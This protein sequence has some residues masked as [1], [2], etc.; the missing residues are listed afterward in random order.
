MKKKLFGLL[1]ACF[2][3]VSAHASD[4]GVGLNLGLSTKSGFSTGFIGA[5]GIIGLP[6]KLAVAPSFNYW[7]PNTQD[8][9]KLKCLDANIDLHFNLLD[10]GLLKVYPLVGLNYMR[11]DLEN[12][13]WG[14]SVDGGESN[15]VG[16]NLGAGAQIRFLP[17][18]GASLEAKGLLIDGFT[19]FIPSATLYFLF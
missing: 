12:T 7:F 16:A 2:V 1:A 15:K 13:V 19:Q 4:F 6:F 11:L 10:L 8:A 14:T 9:L 17:M 5:K 18:L 3:A